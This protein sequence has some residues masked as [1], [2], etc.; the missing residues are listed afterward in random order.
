MLVG[1]S[2]SGIEDS[3]GPPSYQSTSVISSFSPLGANSLLGSPSEVPSQ[4]LG[5]GSRHLST[6][7]LTS[8]RIQ[9]SPICSSSKRVYA[10]SSSEILNMQILQGIQLRLEHKATRPGTTEQGSTI[11]ISKITEQEEFLLR[12]YAVNLAKWVRSALKLQYI[13]LC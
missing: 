6:A 8:P 9:T 13:G 3:V 10:L 1:F 4:L 12:H 2:D 7:S 5:S 11:S